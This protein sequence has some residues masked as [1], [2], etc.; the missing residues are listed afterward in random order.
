MWIGICILVN[1]GHVLHL[2]SETVADHRQMN[3]VLDDYD[4]QMIPGDEWGRNFL[5]FV[6]QLRGKKKKHKNLNQKTN[7]TRGSN[8][9]PLSEILPLDH[10]SGF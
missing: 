2:R 9:G 6:L 10:S 4:G 1:D 5:T 8:P 7:S 3:M